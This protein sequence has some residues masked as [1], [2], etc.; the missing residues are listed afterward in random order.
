MPNDGP[1]PSFLIEIAVEATSKAE[2]EKLD[3]ALARLAAEDPLFGVSSDLESGQ[4]IL[5]GPS[6][7]HLDAKV[8]QL[9]R[10]GIGF[11]VGAP[12]VAFRECITARVQHSYTHK[13]QMRGSGQFASV[14]LAVEPNTPG[15]GHAFISKIAGAV[16]PEKYI[17]GIKAGLESVFS[18]GVVAGFPVVDVKVELIDGKYHD[19]DSSALAFEIATRAC[20][21]EALQ[22]AKSILLE[23]IV[24]AEVVTP[25]HHTG[26]IVA[27]L[28]L[29]RGRILGQDARG[30]VDV[31][32]ALVPL[33]NM[34]GYTSALRQKSMGSATF[35]MQFD[36]Y[37]P[38]GP[39]DDDPPF[40]PAIGMRA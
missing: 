21:R 36:H 40:G 33:M 23:P 4:T 22:K 9:K 31:I 14:T 29:R 25:K 30:D 38:A 24:K 15:T 2:K 17:A 12:Q 3:V 39:N 13:K 32:S 16:V 28:N 27:D 20:F 8:G 6:E 35:S 18:S 7:S 19:V 11:R 26:A 37:A 34:F 5:K 1:T 10:D